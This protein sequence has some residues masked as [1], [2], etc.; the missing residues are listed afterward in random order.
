MFLM[1]FWG[2]LG[3][4]VLFSLLILPMQYRFLVNLK[5]MEAKNKAKGKTQGE[6]YDSMRVDELVL[7]ENMQGN[8]IFFL[9]NL[10]AS[11][12]YRIKH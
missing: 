12:I 2:I 10:L 5:E 11:V 7:H 1:I 6:M 9:A 3:L 8:P 4:Y